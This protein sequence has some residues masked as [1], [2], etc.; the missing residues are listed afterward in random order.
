MG[1]GVFKIINFSVLLKDILDIIYPNAGTCLL[2]GRELKKY[3]RMQICGYCRSMLYPLGDD[4]C[5]VCGRPVKSGSERCAECTNG[6]TY[7]NGASSVFQFTGLVQDAIYRLKYDG[8]IS[9][10]PLLGGFM[11]EKLKMKG[12]DID[13]VIPVPLHPDRL[14]ER[15]FNQS[16]LLSQEI[17]RECGIDV[18]D[19]V[20]ERVLYTKSQVSLSRLERMANVKN[21]FRANDGDIVR[22][23]S[24]LIVDDIMTTGATLNECCRAIR[25]FEPKNIYCLTAACPVYSK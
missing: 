4:V 3:S 10:A 20:L 1:N 15:G 17:G 6:N 22:N 13:L 23:R 21:A 11:A 12:W 19:K 18:S 14:S 2:C 16:Y 25:M 5:R 7:F 9:L 24:V 8:D